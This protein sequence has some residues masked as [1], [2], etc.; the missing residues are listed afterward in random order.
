MMKFK[1]APYNSAYQILVSIFFGA[2]IAA[3]LMGILIIRSSHVHATPDSDAQ[4]VCEIIIAGKS[5]HS[6]DAA[7]SILVVKGYGIQN[8]QAVKVL[9]YAILTYCPQELALMNQ[10]AHTPTINGSTPEGGLA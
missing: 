3:A 7:V 5:M 10:W 4:E 6:V 1:N 9:A 2:L 8:G